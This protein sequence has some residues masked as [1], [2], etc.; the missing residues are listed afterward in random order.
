MPLVQPTSAAITAAID[1]SLQ[2]DGSLAEALDTSVLWAL[3]KASLEPVG[4]TVIYALSSG[5]LPGNPSRWRAKIAPGS[6]AAID[7]LN[8]ADLTALPVTGFVW[9]QQAHVETLDAFY[10]YVTPASPTLPSPSGL[11]VLPDSGAG[12]VWVRIPNATPTWTQ[13]AAWFIDALGDDENNGAGPAPGQALATL[14]ELF[15]RLA[16]YGEVVPPFAKIYKVTIGYAGGATYNLNAVKLSGA[17]DGSASRIEFV[18]KPNVVS[19]NT[20]AASTAPAAGTNTKALATSTN[21]GEVFVPG[22]LLHLPDSGSADTYAA[23]SSGPAAN[24]C[25]L[26]RPYNIFAPIGILSYPAPGD[27]YERLLLPR[28]EVTGTVEQVGQA[29]SRMSLLYLSVAG[30]NPSRP[31]LRGISLYACSVGSTELDG[32][33]CFACSSEDNASSAIVTTGEKTT[34]SFSR[35]GA[36][37]AYAETVVETGFLANDTLTY[38]VRVFGTGLVTMVGSSQVQVPLGQPFTLMQTGAKADVTPSFC[39]LGTSLY[40]VS[41]GDAST[42]NACDVTLYTNGAN[43]TCPGYVGSSGSDFVYPSY[44]VDAWWP[45]FVDGAVIPARNPMPT[46]AVLNAAPYGGVATHVTTGA[47]FLPAF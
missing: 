8:T 23:V 6:A 36:L 27:R 45:P 47:R 31:G 37:D 43:S 29:A 4:P 39:L 10:Y 11:S 40:V 19:A 17:F 26:T 13:R 28:V 9:G 24:Q 16:P 3:N 25:R 22:E 7:V 42:L 2:S 33:E 30:G 38:V 12:G 20:F 41:F 15:N 34:L 5:S 21:A 46:F 14:G 1:D 18:G 32:V 35:I 44:G